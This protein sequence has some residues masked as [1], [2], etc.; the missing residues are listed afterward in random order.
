MEFQ[1]KAA[2]HNCHRCNPH[3]RDP[4]Q[5][6]QQNFQNGECGVK[7]DGSK[8]PPEGQFQLG[9]LYWS[10]HLTTCG[11]SRTP[12]QR[13]VMGGRGETDYIE[14]YRYDSSGALY[15]KDSQEMAAMKRTKSVK[16]RPKVSSHHKICHLES[17]EPEDGKKPM[18][19][20]S[21]SP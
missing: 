13:E 15:T 16:R 14:G 7:N 21:S 8:R 19:E 18:A 12:V 5:N 6:Y 4:A 11:D 17:P 3:R 10:F 1:A 9:G 2:G 20:N